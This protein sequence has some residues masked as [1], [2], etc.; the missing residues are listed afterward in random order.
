MTLNVHWGDTPAFALLKPIWDTIDVP[1]DKSMWE[2]PEWDEQ[3]MIVQL[4]DSLMRSN[5]FMGTPMSTI[6]M[7]TGTWTI[8][9]DNVASVWGRM[10]T[11]ET[12]TTECCLTNVG[13]YDPVRNTYT[14][15]DKGC[16][17]PLS[18]W[19]ISMF[20]GYSANWGDKNDK[21]W[22]AWMRKQEECADVS[23]HAIRKAM[24]DFTSEY[25]TVM[26]E[27]VRGMA[28]KTLGM[29]PVTA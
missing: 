6:L 20:V 15:A 8:T 11:Y 9:A 29:R 3:P 26:S 10:R 27:Y 28:I 24:K 13:K 5:G 2:T 4:L 12:F 18:P 16:T 25:N 22:I 17:H 1:E 14:P 7:L 21:E 23:E 19:M